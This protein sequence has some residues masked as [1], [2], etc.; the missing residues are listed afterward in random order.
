MPLG[1]TTPQPPQF[2]GS[3]L[4]LT[5]RPLQQICS[6]RGMLLPDAQHVRLDPEPQALSSRQ[7]R[8]P[9]S[10]AGTTSAPPI[11]TWPGGQQIFVPESGTTLFSEQQTVGESGVIPPC[12]G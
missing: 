6:S 8:P 5:Q 10:P 11:E 3:L 4:K 1:Q 9:A 12:P 7:Q 2:C